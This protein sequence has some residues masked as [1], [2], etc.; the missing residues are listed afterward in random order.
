[1]DKQTN[2]LPGVVELPP[3][4]HFPVYVLAR[5]LHVHRQ[6]VLNLI[7]SGEI[8][9]AIDIRGAQASRSTI[10]IPR[11]AVEDFLKSRTIVIVQST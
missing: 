8:K 1:L 5:Y 6:H 2:T 10:R 9:C 7:D 4:D 3:G 11:W